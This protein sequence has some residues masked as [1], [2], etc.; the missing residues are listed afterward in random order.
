MMIV[1]LW[2]EM[3]DFWRIAVQTGGW[4]RTLQLAL[5]AGLKSISASSPPLDPEL[6]SC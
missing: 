1:L 2:D 5:H 6:A 4:S 3:D